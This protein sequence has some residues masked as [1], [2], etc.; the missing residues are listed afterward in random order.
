MGILNL[1]DIELANDEEHQGIERD[2]PFAIVYSRRV[3]TLCE[4]IVGFRAVVASALGK[5]D[6]GILQARIV[7][8]CEKASNRSFNSSRWRLS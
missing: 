1:T 6:F 4:T 2:P 5:I 3:S 7:R 8:V